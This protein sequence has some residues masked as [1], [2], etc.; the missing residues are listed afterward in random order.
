VCTGQCLVPKLARRQTR[1]SQEKLGTLLLKFT[2]CS[3]SERRTRQRPTA[4]SAGDAWPKPT[5]T[6]PH[7]TVRCA[8]RLSY[9]PKGLWLHRSA[10]PKKEGNRHCSRSGGAP[11]CPVR[12]RIEG[13]YCLPNGP[14]TAHSCLGL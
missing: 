5:V 3:V 7:W 10:S 1:Y 4:Q 14:P 8:T 11:D 6:R 12:P 13:N 2:N 9:V